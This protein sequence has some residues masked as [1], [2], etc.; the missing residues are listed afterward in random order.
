MG[1]GS[2]N[3]SVPGTPSSETARMQSW[4]LSAS[5][6]LHSFSGPPQCCLQMGVTGFGVLFSPYLPL[7]L[8]QSWK[9]TTLQMAAHQQDIWFLSNSPGSYAFPW[10]LSS[11]EEPCHLLPIGCI[12]FY[13]HSFAYVSGCPF[14]WHAGQF[15]MPT[16]VFHIIVTQI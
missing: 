14:L 13:D 7:Q 1:P 9:P 8:K 2:V 5:C 3:T 10:R 6:W 16:S 15:C 4:G 11:W 12:L